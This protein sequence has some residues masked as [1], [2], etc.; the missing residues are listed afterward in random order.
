[1]KNH[2]LK[3]IA[4]RNLTGRRRREK[5]GSF[6]IN[7]KFWKEKNN[8]IVENEWFFKVLFDLRVIYTYF[9]RLYF[10][11]PWRRVHFKIDS[12]MFRGPLISFSFSPHSSH[13]P[14]P[15]RKTIVKINCDMLSA[16]V[17][18]SLVQFKNIYDYLE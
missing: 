18:L 10:Y 14:P 6:K 12:E 15:L 5:Y 4:T 9:N 8:K 2:W 7:K 3:F 17:F 13:F 16:P 1:M 11:E